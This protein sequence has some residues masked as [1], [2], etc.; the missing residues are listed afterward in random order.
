MSAV[1]SEALENLPEWDLTD[2]YTS[3]DSPRLEEDFITARGLTDALVTDVKGK[4]AALDAADLL[5]AIQRYE[6]IS[7]I[8]GRIMSYAYLVY[9][10]DM[11]DPEGGRFLQTMQ[12]K[13]N[14]I[15]GDLIFFG[16]EMNNLDDDHMA[17]MLTENA[18]LKRYATWIDSVR[19]NKPYQLSDELE[20]LLHDKEVS[21]RSSWIRLFDETCADLKF[22]VGEET[23]GME[24]TLHKLSSTNRDE[25]ATA[26]AALEETFAANSRLF[27]HI[28]NTL[29][30]DKEIE[31]TRRK[32][33]DVATD[34]HLSNAV[35][36]PVIDALVSAV[37]ESY[38]DLSHRYYS[39][40]AKWLGMDKMAYF[41]RN[42]PVP[43]DD[44]RTFT[45]DEAVETVLGA[46]GDFAPWLRDLGQEF[47]DKPWIDAAIRPG[48]APGAFAHPTVPSAHPYLLVN[49]L[50]K[51][52]DV[53]TLAHELG[54][55]VH[56]V[57]ASDQG[58]LLADTPLTLAETASVFGEQLTFRKL[59][60]GA[61]TAEARRA[62]LASKVEDMLN[63]VVR[64][65]AFYEFEREVH[66]A[67]RQGEL[68]ADD[69]GHIWMNIQTAS[70]GPA[71][72]FSDGYKHFWCYIPHFIHSPFYVY[73][74]AFGDCLVNAL[75]AVYE[76]KPDGFADQYRTLLSAGGSQ[77][78]GDL[79]TP[80]GLDASDPAF[81]QKGLGVIR[82]FLD[83]LEEVA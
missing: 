13:V 55:G 52:R 23:L 38:P 4:M 81:W 62:M 47:F 1:S 41:D 53:M 39:L 11:T 25:R 72:D 40:K 56:Q 80:F 74:Y 67:R 43:G 50:G 76:E 70:L 69:L 5:D 37:R 48:K 51:T 16:L 22:A 20:R 2:L 6:S 46:Y 82:T 18:D 28:T 65:T 44:D 66:T 33:P 78:H 7:E 30:K 3:T 54:H 61:Q 42:A 29:A 21:G 9:A 60:A 77:K 15:S 68:S 12:E 83:E 73:A 24:E 32:Y 63:T 14:G 34:R 36:A 10:T 59:L 64:Q 58:P 31:D 71:F 45:W 8:L 19:A 79:L 57:L 27:T 17:K 75:Y 35:E 26:G 49:F